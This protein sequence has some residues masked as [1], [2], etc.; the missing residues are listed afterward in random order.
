MATPGELVEQ[1][2][3]LAE[4]VQLHDDQIK[5]I[6]QVLQQMLTPLPTPRRPIGFRAND[7]S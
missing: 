2:T 3:K 7:D 4:A 5:V 6:N 1:L